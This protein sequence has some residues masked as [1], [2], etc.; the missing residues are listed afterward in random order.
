MMH[1]NRFALVLSGVGLGF[2]LFVSASSS[3][4]AQQNWPQWRGPLANGIAPEADPP[5][6]WSETNHIQWKV[7]IPGNGSA[8]PIIWGQKIFVQTAIRTGKKVETPAPTPPPASTETPATNPPAGGRGGRGMPGGN[9]PSEFFQFA[10]LCL[11]RATGK[12]LWQQVAR[13]EVPHEGFKSGDGSLA[14]SSGVTDGQHLFAFFG[15]RGL[16]CYDLE[17]KLEWSQDLGKM[18]I[19]MGFGEGTSPALYGDTLV[20]NWD[21]EAGSF[22]VAVDKNTGKQ[23]WKVAREEKTSWATPLVLDV[24]GK[25]QV[26]TAATGKIRGYDLASGAVI[27][28]CGGLTRNVIPSPVADQE[29][30]YCMSGYS[31][32]SLLA[33]RLGRTGDLAGTDAIVW[34]HKKNTPYVPSPLLYHGRLYFYAS[35]NGVLSCFNAKSGSAL[36][37]AQRLEGMPN[38]YASPVGAAGRVY[39]TGRNGVSLVLKDADQLEVLATNRLDEKIDA[40]PVAVDQELFLRG[41]EYLYCITGK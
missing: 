35:N 24:A 4:S 31:G 10:V 12:T 6:T 5:V 14:S 1:R 32:N 30:V 25:P 3:S 37:E 29:T 19:V 2:G 17:G 11:D 16:Y 18:R 27:W 39:L 21:N 20:V 38:V 36:Y 7:K 33:I 41:Q 15:S 34:S 13:E 26:I 9:K 40:S 28:E 8:T 23:R 22:V